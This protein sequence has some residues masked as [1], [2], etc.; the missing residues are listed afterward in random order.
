MTSGVG[1]NL[2]PFVSVGKGLYCVIRLNH[3]AQT[4][5]KTMDLWMQIM[6]RHVYSF[7][8]RK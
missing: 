2:K 1:E 3:H 8:K 5:N 4:I 7:G 6:M